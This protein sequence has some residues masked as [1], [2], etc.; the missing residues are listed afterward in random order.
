MDM[1]HLF[2]HS[3]VDGDLTSSQ[4]LAII[5]KAAMNICM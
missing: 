1:P 2:I 3:S 5:N 4:S